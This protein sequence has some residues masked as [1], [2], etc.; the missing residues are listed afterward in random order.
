MVFCSRLSR[1]KRLWMKF[2]QSNNKELYTAP[3]NVKIKLE[4]GAVL[5]TKGTPNSAAYDVYLPCDY[6]V[7][8]GR[9]TL[10]L[11]FRIELPNGY[12][13]MIEPRSGY[14]SKG[15]EGYRLYHLEKSCIANH[16][17]KFDCDV[18]SGKVDADYRGI[19]G[20]IV[21]NRDFQFVMRKG[22]RIAQM[23]IRRIESVEFEET[24]NLSK[25][26]RGAGGFG[27]TNT[28]EKRE[29]DLVS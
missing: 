25:T 29:I 21:V 10:P 7:E 28:T 24:D 4:A 16:L 13:A 15:M 2:I 12:E 6:V 3:I 18:I 5:P 14:S 9:Q 23:T 26:E 22:T 19:V 8:Q 11:N 17:G 20:V 27:H 1:L